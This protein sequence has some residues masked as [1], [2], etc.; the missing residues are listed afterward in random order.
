[1]RK[2]VV[3]AFVSLAIA[4]PLVVQAQTGAAGKDV[5]TV[6]TRKRSR[7]RPVRSR[8]CRTGILT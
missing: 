2:T 6:N 5:G 4:L 7:F 8:G 3:A 1:M